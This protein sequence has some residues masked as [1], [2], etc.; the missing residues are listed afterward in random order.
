M[1]KQ[2]VLQPVVSLYKGAT[3][4]GVQGAISNAANNLSEPITAGASLPQGDTKNSGSATKQS[5]FNATIGLGGTQDEATER[6]IEARQEDLGQ[7]MAKHGVEAGPHIVLPLLGPSNFRYA[8][9]TLAISLANPL[10]LAVG[11]GQGFVKYSNNE[12]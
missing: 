11:T 5:L 10:P 9:G 8:A 7:A 4:E 6:G 1:A 12:K 3:P 2:L